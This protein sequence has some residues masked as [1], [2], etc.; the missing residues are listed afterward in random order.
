MKY[1]C[2]IFATDAQMNTIPSADMPAFVDAHLDYDDALRDSGQLVATEGLEA[3][4]TAAV[5]RVRDGRL[6]VT[7]GPFIETNEQLGGFYLVEAASE[8]EAVRIAAG[9]PSAR[10]GHIELRQVLSL[11]RPEGG[12]S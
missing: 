9:I 10:I 2:L 3:A 5:V 1:L 4:S 6:S 11:L 12:A 7:D 8:N